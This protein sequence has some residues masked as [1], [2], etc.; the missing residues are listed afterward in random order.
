MPMPQKIIDHRQTLRPPVERRPAGEERAGIGVARVAEELRRRRLLAYFAV[1][2]HDHVVGDLAHQCQIVR[3]EEHRHLVALL[4]A[5]DEVHDLAL[6]S[7]VEGGG[8]LIG[9]Q[10]LRL[11]GDRRGDHHTLLLAAGELEWVD[12]EAPLGLADADL[13]QEL[14]DAAA[15]RPA[16]EPEVPAQHLADLEADGEHWIE[17]AHR[18]L[19]D[20]RQL[21]AAQRRQI[22]SLQQIAPAVEDAALPTDGRVLLWQQAHDGKR[23]DRLA[24]ARLA[25][26]R[27]GAP[28]RHVE[29]DALDGAQAARLVDAEI[30]HQVAHLEQVHLSRGSSASR[31]ASV[32]RLNAVTRIAI[33]SVATVSC[34]HLPSKSSLPASA[35]MLPQETVSTP[36][37]KPRKVRIT[38]DLMNSTT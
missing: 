21:A 10:Q 33:A 14:D 17:R 8:R 34:H 3:D 15:D 5:G 22:T 25:H 32:N 28:H 4:Q 23:G 30:D 38:S 24:A 27:D 12:L 29:A 37:P 9:D 36:T 2:H 11:A 13:A 6:H 20:H 31:I 26:E 7:D 18:L 1:A 16:G 19:E 35:S